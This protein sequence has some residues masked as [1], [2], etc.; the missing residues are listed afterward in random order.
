MKQKFNKKNGGGV[1]IIY[2]DT[3]KL[4]RIKEL[5]RQDDEFLWASTQLNGKGLLIG[6]VYKP[7]YQNIFDGDYTIEDHLQNANQYSKNIVVIGDFNVNLLQSKSE[8]CTA[9][10]K[11]QDTFRSFDMNQVIDH[12]TR[13]SDKT[14]TLIDHAWLSTSVN[15]FLIPYLLINKRNTNY[16]IYN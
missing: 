10:E 8:D 12:P 6:A 14:E 7:D 3:L 15:L 11:L 4:K 5:E 9:K 2:K 1:A 16:T 13:L